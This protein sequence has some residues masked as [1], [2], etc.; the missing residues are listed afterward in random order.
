V[1][2]SAPAG[3]ATTRCAVSA[4]ILAGAPAIDAT[5]GAS[6]VASNLQAFPRNIEENNVHGNVNA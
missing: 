2:G 3:T 6:N 1:L 4:E 5:R